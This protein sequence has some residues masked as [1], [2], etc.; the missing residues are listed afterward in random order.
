M[1]CDREMVDGCKPLP[2]RLESAKSAPVGKN[3]NAV[4][5]VQ[6]ALQKPSR[7]RILEILHSQI[8]A[9]IFQFVGGGRGMVVSMRHAITSLQGLHRKFMFALVLTA[10]SKQDALAQ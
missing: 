8:F 6:P 10:C 1:A 4:L 3:W 7:G 5:A 9:V 2:F